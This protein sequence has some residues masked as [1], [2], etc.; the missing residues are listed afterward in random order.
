MFGKAAA[1]KKKP[2]KTLGAHTLGRRWLTT[3]WDQLGEEM[4]AD[5][6][7]KRGGDDSEAQRLTKHQRERSRGRER[8]FFFLK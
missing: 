4:K 2:K 1:E 8:H 7:S 5:D 3:C 6:P